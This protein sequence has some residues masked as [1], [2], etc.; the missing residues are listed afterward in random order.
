MTSGPRRFLVRGMAAGAVGG[1]VAA[2]FTAVV[3]ETHIGYAIGFEDGAALGL[4]PGAAD[5]FSR[6]TQH[7]GGVLATLIFGTA[8]GILLGVVV[9]ALHHRIRAR[10]EFDRAIRVAV[11]AFAAL[12]MIPGL[13]YPPNPPAVGSP[14]TIGTRSTDYLLLVVAATAVVFLGWYFWEWLTSRGIDGASRFLLGGGASAVAV[15]ALFLISPPSPDSITAPD[16]EA[17]PALVVSADAPPEVLEA[18]LATALATGDESL[19]QPGSP[20][21][22]FDLDSIH[23]PADLAGTPVA[24][25]TTKL[26]PQGFTNMIWH[27]R[28]ASFASLALMWA[29]IAGVFGL[30]ADRPDRSAR[31]DDDRVRP[32]GDRESV[33]A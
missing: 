15:T 33:P 18:M 24:I 22:P 7:W 16:N 31:G 32:Y 6:S 28:M 21:E 4:P 5:E 27:F 13:K 3:T 12:V 29:V 9:A 30:L 14:E 1:A 2:G 23:D 25:S 10:S 17:T 26:R 19:R 20:D 11:G 8:M